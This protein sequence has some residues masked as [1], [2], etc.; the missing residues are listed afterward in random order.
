MRDR[1]LILIAEDFEPMRYAMC[2]ILRESY[3]SLAVTDGVELLE[4]VTRHSP[5]VVLLDISMAGIDGMTAARELGS[6]YPEIR[7]VF[8]TAHAD[9]AYLRAALAIGARGY[10]LKRALSTTLVTAVRKVL[11]GGRFVS[12]EMSPEMSP[13]IPAP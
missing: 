8:V 1:P 3:E 5:D 11:A 2:R 6:R 12:P 9:T 13:E 10:V 7:L 4:A